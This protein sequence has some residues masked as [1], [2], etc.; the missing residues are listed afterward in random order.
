MVLGKRQKELVDL[1]VSDGFEIRS[2]FDYSIL[3][4]YIGLYD[5]DGN[6]VGVVS[7]KTLSSLSGKGVFD[8]TE[9]NPS[10]DICVTIFKV[11][12]KTINK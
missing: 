8:I 4:S 11:S 12:N 1:M 10:L 6:E 9:R 3:R 2:Y 7:R 5:G